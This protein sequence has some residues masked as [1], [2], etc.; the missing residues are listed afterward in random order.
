L[1]KR[2]GEIATL[3]S[4]VLLTAQLASVAPAKAGD[5]K[6]GNRLM[7]R[8]L[9]CLLVLGLLAAVLASCGQSAPSHAPSGRIAWQGFLDDSQT[10]AAIFS[11]NTDGSA[12]RQLTHPPDGEEDAWP[13]W[14]PDGSKILFTKSGD[15]C[16]SCDIFLMNADGTGLKQLTHCPQPACLGM[17]VAA[18]SPD[19]KTIA[20]SEGDGPFR[21]NGD[22]TVAAIWLMQADGSHPV[23]LT[24]PPLPASFADDGPA[25]SPD[26]QRLVFERNNQ[27][28]D[29]Q[30]L[31]V[32]NRDGTGLKQ[33]TTWGQLQAGNAHWSPDGTRILFQSY[34]AFPDDTTPQIYTIFPDGTHLVQLTT[35]ERNSWPAWSPD[36]TQII[37]VHRSTTEAD[38][39]AHLYAM[40]ADGSG[41]L[42]IT[43]NKFYQLQPVWSSAP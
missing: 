30:A 28:G 24:H 2:T 7:K 22:A 6:K 42:Q 1:S 38:Q 4:L 11:G 9:L 15:N 17:G 16:G 14:S 5:S 37:F 25:W 41:L 40:K 12:V 23:Q 34:G 43:R 20:Y 35:K 21:A 36:G 19:G 13:A 8:S 18:W 27:V 29:D 26:G 39:N 10:T 33:V 31:F 3:L 32:I